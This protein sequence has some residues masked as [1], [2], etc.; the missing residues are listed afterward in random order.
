MKNLLCSWFGGNYIA[1]E[2]NF[3]QYLD[4]LK[5]TYKECKM[6]IH[7]NIRSECIALIVTT[8]FK[9]SCI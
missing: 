2:R 5:L 8:P 4:K 9:N 6:F 1:C 7:V 3:E